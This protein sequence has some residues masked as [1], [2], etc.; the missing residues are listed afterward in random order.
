[1]FFL[2]LQDHLSGVWQ[3]SFWEQEIKLH[4]EPK[5]ECESGAI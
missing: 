1:M 4:V 5:G 2:I 3:H